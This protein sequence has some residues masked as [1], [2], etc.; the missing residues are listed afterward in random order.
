MDYGMNDNNGMDILAEMFA[1]P[2]PEGNS[3]LGDLNMDA[4][5]GETG[6]ALQD[7][8]ANDTDVLQALLQATQLDG[9]VLP[10]RHHHSQLLQCLAYMVIT[11]SLATAPRVPKRSKSLNGF[12]GSD[13]ASLST[14]APMHFKKA[15]SLAY[16]GCSMH[17]TLCCICH[18]TARQS[19]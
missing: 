16:M 17:S 6:L 13:Y 19:P 11:L 10:P 9:D 8:I 14:A 3:L 1:N 12:C 2:L 18:G 5:R 4:M 15:L 7:G